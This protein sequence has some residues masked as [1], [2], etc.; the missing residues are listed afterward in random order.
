MFFFYDFWSRSRGV[1]NRAFDLILKSDIK[2]VHKNEIFSL[3]GPNYTSPSKG[4][5][6]VYIHIIRTP[7]IYSILYIKCFGIKYRSGPNAVQFSH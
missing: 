7:I 6:I 1:Y 4:R 2:E 3:A 5:C